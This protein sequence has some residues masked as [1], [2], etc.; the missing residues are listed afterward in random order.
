MKKLLVCILTLIALLSMAMVGCGGG[1]THN[2]NKKVTTDKYLKSEATC[3]QKALYNYSCDCGE[4]GEAT[5][6]SGET[7]SHVYENGKCKWCNTPQQSAHTHVYN[8]KVTTDKYLK[9]NAT[10][11][12]KALYN[13]SCD[14]GEKGEATFESGE[15][16][17]HVYENGICKWCEEPETSLEPNPISPNAVSKT[18]WEQ[19]LSSLILT[20]CTNGEFY[21]SPN[22]DTILN[23]Y[24]T[25]E[26]DGDIICKKEYVNNALVYQAY[27]DMSS[28]VPYLYYVNSGSWVKEE[29]PNAES[30]LMFISMTS[31]MAYSCASYYDSFTFDETE[32]YYVGTIMLGGEEPSRVVIRFEN[33]ILKGYSIAQG[34]GLFKLSK[35]GQIELTLPTVA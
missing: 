18:T 9:S 21:V 19:T 6:E 15:T 2:F 35:V 13:Y 5:F 14:C 27:L 26:V 20:P 17:S 4:K 3:S 12:Q 8:K 28:E 11:S 22:S 24:I 7:S 16:S 1:H 10:C 29:Y 34:N 23:E 32:S 31:A 33:G 30:D 25:F